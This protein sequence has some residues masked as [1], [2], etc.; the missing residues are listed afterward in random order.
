MWTKVNAIDI[1]TMRRVMIST[2]IIRVCRA[3]K[4]MKNAELPIIGRYKLLRFP[5]W[6]NDSSSLQVIQWEQHLGRQFTK[7]MHYEDRNSKFMVWRKKIESRLRTINKYKSLCLIVEFTNSSTIKK[8]HQTVNLQWEIME[9]H[10]T[11]VNNREWKKTNR[12]RSNY[13]SNNK[14]N[15]Y[16]L[17][18]TQMTIFKIELN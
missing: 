18:S 13:K 9:F 11:I 12:Q 15:G 17:P 3:L 10:K 5:D 4:R 8:K 16:K 2:R 7:K 14:R 6:E 1:E